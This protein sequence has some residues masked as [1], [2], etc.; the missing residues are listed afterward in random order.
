MANH[1]QHNVSLKNTKV[2]Q[3]TW[4]QIPENISKMN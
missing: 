4:L 3:K 1:A 2:S